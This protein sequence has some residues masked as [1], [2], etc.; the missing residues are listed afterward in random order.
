MARLKRAL[1]RGCFS[2]PFAAPQN[3]KELV[4]GV[5]VGEWGMGE[6]TVRGARSA[7]MVALGYAAYK[8]DTVRVVERDL[9]GFTHIMAS[10]QGLYVVNG[11]EWRLVVAGF[12]FGITLRGDEIFVFECCDLP[13]GP[14]RMGRIVKLT[15]RGERIVSEEV[16]ARGL[17]NG[18]H[19]IDLV[20]GRLVVVDTYNQQLLRFGEELSLEESE[21]EVLRPLPVSPT[22][23]WREGESDYH[24]ANSLLAVGEHRLLLLHNLAGEVGRKSEI[25]ICDRDWVVKAKVTVNGTGCH[26]LAL[27]EDGTVLT[28][29]SMEGRVLGT[30]GFAMH[31]SPFMTRGLA[32][33]PDS[34]VVGASRWSRREG[35]MENSGTITFMT[36]AWEVEGVLM[37]PA[38]PTELRRL[39]GQDAGL[40]GYLNGVGW[41]QRLQLGTE[42]WKMSETGAVKEFPA[43]PVAGEWVRVG[44][45]RTEFT[46]DV[47]E[48]K[49]QFA[50]YRAMHLGQ[51]FEPGFLQTLLRFSAE[52]VFGPEESNAGFREKEL[53]PKRVGRVISLALNRPELLRWLEEVTGCE[54]LE[55]FAGKLAQTLRRK[56][57][58]LVW[59]DDYSK[60]ELRR[61]AVVIDMS[62]EQYEGG[63]FQLRMR[64][65]KTP[66]LEHHY[67]RVGS[68][69]IFEVGREVEHRVLPLVSGG[70]RRI[71]AGWAI[72]G[73]PA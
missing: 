2:I 10:R 19:Q 14:T 58:E 67:E 43:A 13:R 22:K 26:G 49:A 70:P 33:G 45:S 51:V 66:L 63:E 39:D 7:E 20:E 28:T 32:V 55:S 53:P 15:V 46:G 34:A 31:V 44:P 61:L 40:S 1:K 6:G 71:F 69:L 50:R 24:H 52:T 56:G 5:G 64:E 41:G 36:R 21:Y 38:A 72:S 42:R 3:R 57:D 62:T 47:A 65:D 16:V 17:D 23:Q 60:G 68:A 25:A 54:R 18:C 8:S 73:G 37:V 30:D 27:Q 12:F 35:R 59:H 4:W 48:A 9:R 11:F 29:G